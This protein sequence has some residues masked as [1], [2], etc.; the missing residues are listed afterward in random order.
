[1]LG[2]CTWGQ[3]PLTITSGKTCLLQ[4]SFRCLLWLLL[5]RCLSTRWLPKYPRRRSRGVLGISCSGTRTNHL[6]LCSILL[7]VLGSEFAAHRAMCEL[8]LDV[9]CHR[10]SVDNILSFPEIIL[11]VKMIWMY[12][13][14][15]IRSHCFE[16][17]ETVGLEEYAIVYRDIVSIV[18]EFSDGDR[19]LGS[20]Q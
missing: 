1:M 8:F 14:K 3:Q 20:I 15:Y 2:S 11:D 13:G 10:W 9:C 6:L 19:D 12:F 18:P 17:D 5:Q 7:W 16:Y 4:C